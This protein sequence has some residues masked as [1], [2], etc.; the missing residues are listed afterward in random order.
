MNALNGKSSPEKLFATKTN[1]GSEYAGAVIDLATTGLKWSESLSDFKSIVIAGN[2]TVFQGPIDPN[3][4][5][6]TAFANDI[7]AIEGN[8]GGET[9]RG[10]TATSKEGRFRWGG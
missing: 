5:A 2:E 10:E 1:G 9:R 3:K 4:A 7:A 8:A 6:E